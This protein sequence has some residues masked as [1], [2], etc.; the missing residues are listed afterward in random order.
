MVGWNYQRF[1]S[2]GVHAYACVRKLA[3]CICIHSSC[4]RVHVHQFIWT[5]ALT[6]ICVQGPCVH[7]P[8]SCVCM[9]VLKNQFS[10]G[11]IFFTYFSNT[12]WSSCSCSHVL[13]VLPP[14]M[15]RDSTSHIIS[16]YRALSKD[17]KALEHVAGFEPI[18]RLLPKHVYAGTFLRT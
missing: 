15:G 16:W 7:I 3:S 6:C 14:F 8:K 5:H 2:I 4:I 1:N 18:L 12:K 10:T 9:L 17:V 11:L 13:K